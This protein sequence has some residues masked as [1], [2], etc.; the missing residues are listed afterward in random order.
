MEVRCISCTGL[1]EA[2]EASDDRAFPPLPMADVQGVELVQAFRQ[3]DLVLLHH[4]C[5]VGM[6]WDPEFN[7][8]ACKATRIVDEGARYDG[9]C[10]A[11]CELWLARFGPSDPFAP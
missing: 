9:N 4:D 5:R 1:A 10:R 11:C 3:N 7:W 6:E 8:W 2:A